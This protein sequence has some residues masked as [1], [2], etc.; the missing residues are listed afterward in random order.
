MHIQDI[1]DWFKNL[2]SGNQPPTPAP[3]LKP[4]FTPSA[5]VKA[6]VKQCLHTLA[7]ADRA[8]GLAIWA[9]PEEKEKWLND[10]SVFLTFDNLESVS[11]QFLRADKTVEAE[12]KISFGQRANGKEAGALRGKEVPVL[13]RKLV[14]GHR[15]IVQHKNSNSAQYQGLLRMNWS[16][17]E[18]L[19]RR[20][21]DE[22]DTAQARHTSGRQ[23]GSIFASRDSR[24]ELIVTRPL[25]K[26]GFG[27][28]SC[29]QL[30]LEGI[31]LHERYLRGVRE[32]KLGQRVTA[33]IIQLP[34]GLQAR[35][36][37]A[38]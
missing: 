30:K 25:G 4:T 35:E 36:V 2:F 5:R 14:A 23:T 21:G 20:N 32:L 9:T 12:M 27:F 31:F 34:D 38:A 22:F 17:A 19:R 8:Y 16:S 29:P 6:E 24:H 1:P 7:L 18:T 10:L 33:Q 3:Q 26:K 11:L 28:A 13:D 15:V 37:R